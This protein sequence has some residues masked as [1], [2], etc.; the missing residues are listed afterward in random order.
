VKP[1]TTGDVLELMASHITSA[2]LGAAMELGLFWLLAE[3]PR[4]AA[5]VGEALAIPERRC[6]YWL[7]LLS[8]MGLLVRAGKAYA[9]SPT[10]R[11][12]ILEVYGQETWA[13]LAQE[14]R[15]QFPAFCDLALRIREF[16]STG[17]PQGLTLHD[18]VARMEEEPERARRFTRMLYEINQPLADELANALDMTGVERLMD[19]GG[20]SGVVSLALLRRHPQLTAT[21]VDIANVCEVG[22][23]IAMEN[24][25]EERLTYHA[26]DFLQDEL[27]SGFDI[28]LE[29]DVSV[30]GEGLFRKLREALNPRGRLVIVDMLAPAEGVAPPSRLDWAFRDSLDDPDFTIPTAAQIQAQLTQAG[31]QSLSEYALPSGW[32]VIEARKRRVGESTPP[33]NVWPV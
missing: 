30:Y 22:R 9:P 18:Y 3:Q 25:M 1:T 19:L 2:A 13:F 17:A 4:D 6:G 32:T 10:A 21:V 7:E 11:A 15:E 33:K 12:A 14:A 26:A 28:V 24:S 5:G 8:K 29:C 20:G 27:P 31:F 23:E 16:D